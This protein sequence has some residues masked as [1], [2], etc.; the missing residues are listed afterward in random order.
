[1]QAVLLIGLQGS[2]KTT[3]YRERF[4]ETHAHV[5]LDEVGTRERERALIADCIARGVPFVVDNTNILRRDRAVY[6]AIAKQA[7]YSV[8][9]YYFAPNVRTSIGRNKHRTDKKPV[10]VP[11]ILSAFK[12]LEAPVLAEGFDELHE[13]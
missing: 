4:S 1:M 5:S 2:G 6:I 13:I 7:G 9:G 8:A 12:R 10:A 11:A 3:F